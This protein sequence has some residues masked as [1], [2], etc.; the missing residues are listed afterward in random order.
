[1]HSE[2]ISES[3]LTQAAGLA[4]RPQVPPHDP[5]QVSDGHMNDPRGLLL[6]SLQTYK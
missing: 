6:V 2:L 3:F 1:M 4:M 5:L